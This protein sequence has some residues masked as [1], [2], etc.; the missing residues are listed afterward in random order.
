MSADTLRL[1]ALVAPDPAITYNGNWT[2]TTAFGEVTYS[3][4]ATASLSFTG[5]S[6]YVFGWVGPGP[7]PT[8]AIECYIDGNM[9]SRGPITLPG[10]A[11]GYQNW[12]QIILCEEEGLVN[13]NHT[14][15]V[16]VS[17]ATQAYPLMLDMFMFRLS[18]QQ[19]EGLSDNLAEQNSSSTI[20]IIAS[21]TTSLGSGTAAAPAAGSSKSSIVAPMVGGVVGA[22]LALLIVALGVFFIVRRRKHAYA[23][24]IDSGA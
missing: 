11:Q 22:V 21:S 16:V 2:I 6:I 4:G 18:T 20:P 15:K 8:P 23:E 14:M 1:V 3:P 13:M 9:T 5:L 7:S 24:I 19:F 10:S 12:T 17:Q